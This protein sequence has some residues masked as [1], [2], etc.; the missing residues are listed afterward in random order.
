VVLMDPDRQPEAVSDLVVIGGGVMGLFTAYHASERFERIAVVERGIVGDPATASYG[1]TRSFRNDYLDAT[2][3]R[4]AHE[5]FRLWGE[6]EQQTATNVLVRCGCLNIAKRSVTPNLADTYAQLSYETLT[7][8]GLR[9]AAFEGPALRRRYPY[10][11]ADMGYLDVDAG[12]VD[13]PAVTRTLTRVLRERG[14]EVLEGVE[15]TAIE[16][17]RARIRVI[18]DGRELVTRALVVTAGHGTNDVLSRLPGCRLQVPIT[19][20]RPREAKYFA[21]PAAVRDRFT[22]GAMPAIAYLDTG[23][24][25]HPIV[26]G[27]VD[28]VKIGY[29]NPPDLPRT[30][31]AIDGIASFVERCMPGLRTATARDVENVDQC[32]YDLVADDDFVLGPIPG[33][34]NAFVGVGWRG[35]GYKFA[36]WVGR[37]LAELALQGGTVY[38]IGR[39]DP[40][41]FD[42]GRSTRDAIAADSAAAS[43]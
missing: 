19:K 40:A 12:V 32:H 31:T 35:T 43:L 33:F 13:L 30:T 16:R 39:F 8:L 17:D 21:P 9:T 11:D 15:T 42:Q 7:R 5:A 14:V 4:F 2:Y 6:F 20:D 24:Y 3:A 25:C 18:A 27:L 41:R 38:D 22:A 23:I 26:D 1:L 36:P 34:A 28:A 29:Y 37:V 10:L